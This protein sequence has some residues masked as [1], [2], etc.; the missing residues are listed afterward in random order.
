MLH[1]IMGVTGVV[2]VLAFV[3]ITTAPVTASAQTAGAC[4]VSGTATI[5][6]GL[7]AVPGPEAVAFG[8]NITCTGVVN[9]SVAVNTPEGS[10]SGN[11]ACSLGGL[12]TCV[13]FASINYA[14]S[15][16]SCS[17]GILLQQGVLV[18]VVCVSSPGQVSVDVFTPNGGQTTDV[19]N[20]SFNGVAAGVAA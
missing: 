18:E 20:V 16:L 6:P 10:F 17:S 13:P 1:R 14:S 7:Q 3:G 12:I 11:V 15:V 9:G 5:N 19:T 4:T 2:S 8:G